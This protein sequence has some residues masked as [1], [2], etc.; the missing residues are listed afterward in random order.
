MTE[1]KHPLR[2]AGYDRD[3]HL[4]D[5]IGRRQPT[6]LNS[7]W[8]IRAIPG[9]ARQFERKV[10]SEFWSQ[11]A[12][13]EGLPIAIIACPCGEEPQLRPAGMHVC[14]CDRM[15]LSLGPEIRVG[16]SPDA[17]KSGS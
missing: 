10:P 3:G 9:L 14:E 6:K 11:D 12:D 2:I 16:N 7:I 1:F 13:D 15:Y 4:V 5:N 8:A 17:V